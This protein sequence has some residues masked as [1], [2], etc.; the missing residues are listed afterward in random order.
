MIIMILTVISWIETFILNRNIYITSEFNFFRNTDNVN[1]LFLQ[2]NT[3]NVTF[4]EDERTFFEIHTSIKAISDGV[5][6][7]QEI[8]L[9]S[10]VND[11]ENNTKMILESESNAKN[12][13]PEIGIV[14]YESD[15]EKTEEMTEIMKTEKTETNLIQCENKMDVDID[16]ENSDSAEVRAKYSLYRLFWGLQSYMSSENGK[17]FTECPSVNLVSDVVMEAAETP[18]NLGNAL[19]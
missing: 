9:N 11:D 3:G 19:H 12:I 13:L 14:D 16:V 2:V 10:N 7:S 1:A 4:L 17:R 15:Q 5:H 8:N 18:S 6:Q